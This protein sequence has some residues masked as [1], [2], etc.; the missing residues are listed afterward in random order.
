VEVKPFAK[1]FWK[2]SPIDTAKINKTEW[3]RVDKEAD[4]S[5]P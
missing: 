5:F 2:V 1:I 3:T 4:V